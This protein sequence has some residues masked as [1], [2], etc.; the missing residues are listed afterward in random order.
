[1]G[2]YNQFDISGY[3]SKPKYLGYEK[4]DG[5]NRY[6]IS[7]FDQEEDA[8]AFVKDMRKMGIK[9]A[10]VAR[11]VDGK[12]LFEWDKNPKFKDK[13]SPEST[14]ENEGEDKPVKKK[15]KKKSKDGLTFH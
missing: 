2:L 10:F 8:K 11:Y 14:E 1:M 3:F 5:G 7:Y 13:K 15:A 6:V 4:V 9:D 12:R